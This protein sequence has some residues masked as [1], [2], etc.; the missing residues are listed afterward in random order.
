[1]NKEQFVNKWCGYDKNQNGM[2]FDLVSVVE[3]ERADALQ[4]EARLIEERYEEE[5]LPEK[6]EGVCMPEDDIRK[7]IK[8]V[9]IYGHLGGMKGA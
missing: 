8:K 3:N 1:M 9:T 6:A 4:E 7:Y 5:T 2:M